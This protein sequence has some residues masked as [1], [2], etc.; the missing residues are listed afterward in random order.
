MFLY[1]LPTYLYLLI[2]CHDATSKFYLKKIKVT[3]HD[4]ISKRSRHE[5]RRR[6]S[7]I[8]FFFNGLSIVS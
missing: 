2:I 7:T 8:C 1:H 4:V 5:G 6:Y 3:K